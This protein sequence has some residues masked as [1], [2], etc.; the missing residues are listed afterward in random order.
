MLCPFCLENTTINH[1]K[2]GKCDA[3][4]PV[5]YVESHNRFRQPYIVSL[6]GF[7][8]HGKTV[9]LASLLYTLQDRLPRIWPGFYRRGLSQEAVDVLYENLKMLQEGTLPESTRRNFPRPNIHELCNIPGEGDRQ[10]LIYDPPGEAFYK[11]AAMQEYAGF[12]KKA[13]VVLFLMSLADMDEPVSHEMSQLLEV[14]T[15]GMAG[16]KAKTH[17]QDLVVVL[18][19]ADLLLDRMRK[20]PELVE[21]LRQGEERTIGDT[22]RYRKTLQ[23]VSDQIAD[24][25]TSDLG[26]HAFMS[27]ATREF[28]SVSFC[29]MSALGSAP[30][31]GHLEVGMDPHRVVDPL[32][33]VMEK[34]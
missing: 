1:T 13:N 23:R 16:M 6:V 9:Y 3:P 30:V 24:F 33:W 25:A 17:K 29:A 10:L 14:Y 27:H 28:K 26:A 12:V 34:T 18:T 11:D 15:L 19:K 7:S 4:L 2:C 8:G 21:Y 31:D 5:L 22:K 32:M 20:R